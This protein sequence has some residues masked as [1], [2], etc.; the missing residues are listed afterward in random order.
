[1]IDHDTTTEEAKGPAGDLLYRWGSPRTHGGADD[2]TVL[3]WQH[4]AYWIPE[5]GELQIFNNGGLRGPDG[6]YNPGELFMGILDGSYSDVL[7]LKMP[8]DASGNWDW[9]KDVE[10]TWSYNSDGSKGMKA[11]F[12]SGARKLPNG[13]VLMVQAQNNR[14]L[15]V[16][17]GGETV[18]DFKM[19]KPGR[20]FRLYKYSKDYPGLAGK[21]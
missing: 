14:V 19:P 6:K 16:T 13:N 3:F 7:R 1:M 8:V 21:L 11:P 5:T 20:I 9:S 10:V 12:M 4:D 2:E 18:L 17:D 15:E